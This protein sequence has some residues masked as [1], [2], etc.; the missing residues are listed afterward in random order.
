MCAESLV[1]RSGAT[2]CAQDNIH[3]EIKMTAALQSYLAVT[4]LLV[5][6]HLKMRRAPVPV[7]EIRR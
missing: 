4:A 7:S 5:M 6:N 2:W 3:M 1:L